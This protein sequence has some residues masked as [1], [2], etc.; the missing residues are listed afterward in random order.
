VPYHFPLA[1]GQPPCSLHEASK[2]PQDPAVNRHQGDFV[3]LATLKR[4]D[5]ARR[6]IFL[7]EKSELKMTISWATMVCQWDHL[8]GKP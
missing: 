8:G 1:S 3:W 5:R 2:C 6:A 7:T 4:D